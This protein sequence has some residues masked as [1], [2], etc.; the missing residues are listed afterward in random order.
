MSD[1]IAAM[2]ILTKINKKLGK[3]GVWKNIYI[4]NLFGHYYGR[5]DWKIFVCIRINCLFPIAIHLVV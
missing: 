5:I 1:D 4:H 3:V 2:S